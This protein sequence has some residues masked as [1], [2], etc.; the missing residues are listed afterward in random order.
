M[1]HNDNTQLHPKKILLPIDFSPSSDAALKTATEFAQHFQSQLVLL[2]IV[3]M[4]PIISADEFS[5]CYF[6]QQEF[7]E[8]AKGKAS[9]RLATCTHHLAGM[10]VKA[11]SLVEVGNDV[12]GNIMMVIDREHIDMLVIS[13]HGTSGWKPTIFG[14]I[15]EKVI[16]LA[17][18]PILLLRSARVG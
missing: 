16:R 5:T 3:P 6:P 13:T 17:G 15:A 11:T 14:S 9:E 4:I 18:C 7:L 12:V 10:G 8:E 2:N 1:S